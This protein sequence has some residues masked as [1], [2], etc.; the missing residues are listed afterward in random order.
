MEMRNQIIKKEILKQLYFNKYLSIATLSTHLNK[1]IPIILKIV[2]E[3]IEEGLVIE[4]GFAPSTGGRRA[5]MYSVKTGLQYIIA[6]AMDQFITRIAVMDMNNA[7]TGNIEKIDLPLARNENALQQLTSSIENFIKNSGIAKE[8]I[9]GIGI[10]MPGFIDAKKGLNYS[11]LESDKSIVDSIGQVTTL[12]VFI[13]NDSSLIALA[14]LKFGACKN[15][16]NAMVINIGWGVGLGMIL[17]SKLYRG[18]NGFAGE[19]SHI[20]LFS[21]NKLCSCGKMGCLETETSLFVIIEKAKQG[22]A[23]G[24][25]SVLK[26]QIFDADLE[27]AFELIVKAAQRGDQFAIELISKAAYEIGRGVSILIHLLNP[28]VIILS[29]RGALAGKLWKAPIQ[30]A[31]NEYSIPKLAAHTEI[32]ISPLDRE[33]ELIGAAALVMENFETTGIKSPKA[34][35]SIYQ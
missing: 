15:K 7:I 35:L 34:T 5:V 23:D 17:N 13:D 11:F 30:Q 19:F 28:E 4:T 3:L 1:S 18:E 20:S 8:K 31:I 16:K 27:T 33:A 12:P 24:R 2:N 6:V 9:I 21:N 10:G 22:L 26:H 32:E 29:G 14:E 25:T